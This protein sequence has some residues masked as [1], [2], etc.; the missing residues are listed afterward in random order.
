MEYTSLPSPTTLAS[1]TG[2][3]DSQT[4]PGITSYTGFSSFNA[5]ITATVCL[6]SGHETYYLEDYDVQTAQIAL[7][8]HTSEVILQQV[9]FKIQKYYGVCTRNHSFYRTTLSTVCVLPNETYNL[10][11]ILLS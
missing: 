1:F 8:Q 2:C 9:K 3:T 7:F 10:D 11:Y 4:F 6:S 5:G